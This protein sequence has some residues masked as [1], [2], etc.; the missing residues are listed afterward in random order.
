MMNKLLA[1]MVRPSRLPLSLWKRM[2]VGSFDLR[3]EY[4]IFR[5]PHY[6]YCLYHS[7]RLAQFLGKE[8]ISVL[9][10]GVAGGNGLIELE[11]LADEIERDFSVKI[12]IYGFDTG[13]GLPEPVDYRDLPYIWK[14]GFF[15]MDVDAL[16][17]RLRRSE[18]VLGDVRDTVP[19]FVERTDIAPIGAIM[20]DL[21]FYSS[22]CDALRV[23]EAQPDMLLPR[24]WCYFDDILSSDNGILCDRVGVPLAICE[25][26]DHH[27]DKHIAPIAGF[28][29]HRRVNAPW[30]EKIYVHHW[31]EHPEYCSYVHPD[32][33]RHLLLEES[34]S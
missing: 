27:Q 34:R 25:F 22:T 29:G 23:L 31:F 3:L 30:N 28:K 16:K 2:P 12:D 5:R 33:S 26:N 18:L 8:S 6:A 9:E 1:L 21:D 7:A 19:A 15:N 17:K 13:G 4:D 32:E 14:A 24:L 11:N 20:F 10:F